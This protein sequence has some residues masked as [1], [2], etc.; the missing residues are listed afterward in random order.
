M[1]HRTSRAT[2]T[3]TSSRKTRRHPR[4][5]QLRLD[6]VESYSMSVSMCLATL[7]FLL[8]DLAEVRAGLQKE[9]T[10]GL[11]QV[12]DERENPGRL[13]EC[14]G[15][16]GVVD[17]APPVDTTKDVGDQPAGMADARPYLYF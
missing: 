5:E 11:G 4:S 16:W 17:E 9:L 12:A 3:S 8:E 10:L 13:F 14:G 1:G 2:V 7:G 15:S 6:V